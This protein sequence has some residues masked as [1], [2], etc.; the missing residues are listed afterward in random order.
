MRIRGSGRWYSNLSCADVVVLHFFAAKGPHVGQPDEHD[1]GEWDRGRGRE[2]G[3]AVA[4]AA[5][6]G[7]I[8]IIS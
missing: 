2:S 3:A 6:A 7:V 8:V 5:A 1:D 4:A